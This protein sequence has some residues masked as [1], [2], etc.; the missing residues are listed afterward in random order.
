MKE[1]TNKVLITQKNCSLSCFSC[2]L[3]IKKNDQ[4]AEAEA[5]AKAVIVEDY[6]KLGPIK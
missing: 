4:R 3:C 2:R 6:R 1:S 5:R